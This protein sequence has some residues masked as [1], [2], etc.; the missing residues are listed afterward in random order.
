[1]PNNRVG[2][3]ESKGCI[4]VSCYSKKWPSAFP[5]SGKGKKHERSIVLNKWQKEI[6]KSNPQNMMKGL[7]HS[8]GCRDSN[9]IN[10]K[11][12]PR[13][14][15]SNLSSDILDIFCWVC[16][17][18]DIKYKRSDRIVSIAKRED[19]EKMDKW[20]GPKK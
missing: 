3:V 4:D 14:S 2:L 7:I 13:Y 6:V 12:Y 18:L 17:L 20:I 5:Q 19:V 8:D 9:I 11:S 16:Q 10:G 1:M 15:F